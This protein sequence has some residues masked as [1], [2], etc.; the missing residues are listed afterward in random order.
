MVTLGVVNAILY[1]RLSNSDKTHGG[2]ARGDYGMGPYDPCDS[3]IP[4]YEFHRI[5]HLHIVVGREEGD[6]DCSTT[7]DHR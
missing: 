3:L 1:V 2:A 6:A 5:F 7:S 4:H